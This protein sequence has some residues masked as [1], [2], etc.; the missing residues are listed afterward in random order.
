MGSI[1]VLIA[2]IQAFAAEDVPAEITDSFKSYCAVQMAH[3]M[4]T[5]KGSQ[6]SVKFVNVSNTPEHW[7]KFSDSVDTAYNCNVQKITSPV[8]SYQGTLEVK[9][10]TTYYADS[11]SE[12]E[13]KAENNVK[14]RVKSI[15]RFSLSY[16]NGQWALTKVMKYSHWR[17]KWHEETAAGIIDALASRN[18][19]KE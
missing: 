18:E 8:L 9:A 11:R 16:Q 3:V 13:A 5:Y 6:Y 17:A 14:D 15:Y 19:I 7:T 10:T 1:L 2:A 4:D 12:E